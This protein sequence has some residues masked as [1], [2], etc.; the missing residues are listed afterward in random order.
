MTK[1]KQWGFIRLG[2][3]G[4][5]SETLML[6][7]APSADGSLCENEG[8]HLGQ[9]R[10]S[11]VRTIPGSPDESSR[12]QLVRYLA[13]WTRTVVVWYVGAVNK[14]C[15]QNDTLINT[16]WEVNKGGREGQCGEMLVYCIGRTDSSP[17]AGVVTRARARCAVLEVVKRAGTA[18]STYLPT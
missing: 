13:P 7:A 6:P 11:A 3:Q 2:R 5:T 8:Q 10:S 18:E 1:R 4:R 14:R 17:P 16:R 15:Q 9:E 12:Q